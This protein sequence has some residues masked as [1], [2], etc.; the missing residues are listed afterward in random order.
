MM[1]LSFP[2]A[3]A[4]VHSY[5]FNE[6]V[7]VPGV[8]H[9]KTDPRVGGRVPCPKNRFFSWVACENETIIVLIHD[10]GPKNDENS[11]Y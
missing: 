7:G 9:E 3:R 6:W 1:G 10:W 4:R 5:L 8:G 11:I 2:I